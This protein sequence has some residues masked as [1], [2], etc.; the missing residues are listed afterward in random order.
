MTASS[1]R[2]P[3]SAQ[4]LPGLRWASEPVGEPTG[5]TSDERRIARRFSP[6]RL[7]TFAAGRRAARRALGQPGTTIDR[8][9]HGQPI[10]PT[11][12][13]G[14]ITHTK[15]IALAVCLPG[16]PSNAP[17]RSVGI[18]L[19]EIEAVTADVRQQITSRMELSAVEDHLKL[20]PTVALALIFG[21][22]EAVYKA[23]FPLF[24]EFIGYRQA[25][26]VVNQ[27]NRFEIRFDQSLRT[28][29]A[30]PGLAGY[31]WTDRKH[32]LTVALL[33]PT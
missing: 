28:A 10:W 7:A 18:D 30:N 25:L 32:V 2:L 16:G 9:Q 6:I 12:M 29:A 14:S 23:A 26:I 33:S 1:F 31:Y 5:L 13:A 20:D 19:E 3:P 21:A 15:Q 8:G 24:E 11:G 4:Q 22:K 27:P 17:T